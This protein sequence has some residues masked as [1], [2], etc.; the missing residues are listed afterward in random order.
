MAFFIVSLANTHS[1]TTR[2]KSGIFKPK[3][4]LTHT[5]STSHIPTSISEALSSPQWLQA[6]TDEYN[7]LLTNHTWSLTSLPAGAKAV[8]CKWLF[9]NKFNADGSFQRH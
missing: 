1:M 3:T 4:F 7:A 8:G 9:K 2:S 6:M 5:T